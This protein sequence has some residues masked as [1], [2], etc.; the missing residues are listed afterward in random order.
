MLQDKIVKIKVY[1]DPGHGWGAVKIKV[2]KELGIADKITAYSYQKGAT[3]YL[4]EDLDLPL[5]IETLKRRAVFYLS[6]IHI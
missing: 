2:L 5:L 6:L 1:A 3:A 4:E